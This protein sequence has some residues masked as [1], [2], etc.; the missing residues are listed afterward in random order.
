MRVSTF[1]SG[2]RLMS[3]TFGSKVSYFG[4]DLEWARLMGVLFAAP[5]S[6]KIP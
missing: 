1:F 5:K 6:A 3:E 2:R 4:W